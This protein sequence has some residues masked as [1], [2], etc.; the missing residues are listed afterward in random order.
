MSLDSQSVIQYIPSKYAPD[1]EWSLGPLFFCLKVFG[2]P[3]GQ[4][5]W[6]SSLRRKLVVGGGAILVIWIALSKLCIL[7]NS[8]V[9][10]NE[11]DW[12]ISFSK[13]T[14]PVASPLIAINLFWLA[15]MQWTSLW[16]T[17][18]EIDMTLRFDR[19]FYHSFRR[20]T[21]AAI[22]L[23]LTVNQHQTSHV[24]LPHPIKYFL[25]IL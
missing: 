17:A 1:L 4:S 3:I 21:T 23:L 20:A 10:S 22:A 9:N 8:N 2:V 11:N 24:I 16:N 14:G 19:Q 6:S 15:C 18:M 7:F 5:S 12:I 13:I 25:H